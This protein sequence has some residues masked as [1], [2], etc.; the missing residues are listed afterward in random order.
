MTRRPDPWAPV[1]GPSRRRSGIEPMGIMPGSIG[2]Y[3]GIPVRRSRAQAVGHVTM[4]SEP[5]VG[6]EVNLF[7]PSTWANIEDESMPTWAL[8]GRP[9]LAPDPEAAR[10]ARPRAR[11]LVVGDADRFAD[12]YVERVYRRAIADAVETV[13]AGLAHL[14]PRDPTIEA[15]EDLYR[16][17]P[18][19]RSFP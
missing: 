17:T 13:R 14:V 10:R 3:A 6:A 2:H 8:L 9:D 12:P 19:A 16:P 4:L 5:L 15:I 11:T 1:A 18:P 7:A